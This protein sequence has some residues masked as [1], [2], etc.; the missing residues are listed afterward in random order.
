MYAASK[1]IVAV[2]LGLVC[3]SVGAQEFPNKPIRIIVPASVATSSDLSARFL[4]EALSK[5]FGV[6]VF[7]DNKTGANGIL[8]VQQLLGAPADGH[9]LLVTNSSLY[10]NPALYKSVPYDPVR[11][12]RILIGINQV[13]LVLVAGPNM[14]VNTVRQLIDYAKE[15]PGQVTYASASAGSSTHLGPELFASRAG[16]SLRHVPYKGGAQAITD[17]AGGHVNI[18]M[19][20]V[21]TA[22]PLVNAGKLKALAVTGGSRSSALPNVPTLAEAGLAGAEIVSKQS[23]VAQTGIPE[24]VAMKL[25]AAIAKILKSPEYAKFLE[26]QGIEREPMPPEQYAKIGADELKAWAEMVRLSG[27][28]FD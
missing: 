15:R 9:T 13:F 8:G 16:I 10:A 11:D 1:R 22:V 2:L 27:A 3:S 26:V 14:N 7:V 20:A 4:A 6:N 25:T 28:K 12:F 18:A 24:A 5:D 23:I 17:T 21:P 19:T